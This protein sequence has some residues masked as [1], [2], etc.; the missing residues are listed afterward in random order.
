MIDY[1]R[2]LGLKPG[3]SLGEIKKAYHRYAFHFHPDRNKEKGDLFLVVRE[4]YDKL[5]HMAGDDEEKVKKGERSPGKTEKEPHHVVSKKPKK[6]VHNMSFVR[7]K[8]KKRASVNFYK[9]RVQKVILEHKQCVVCRGYGVVENRFH[10]AENCEI[11]GGTGNHK[12]ILK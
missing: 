7:E 3:A 12:A 5:L 4:A 11:C 8:I 9:H 6:A 10:L 1:Y 2:I